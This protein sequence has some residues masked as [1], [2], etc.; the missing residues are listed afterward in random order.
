MYPLLGNHEVMR[1]VG[2]WRYVSEGEYQSF[3]TGSSSDVRDAVY[4]RSAAAE[5]SRAKEQKRAFD[6]A[7]FRAQFMREVPLGY[8]EMR[9]AFAEQGEYGRWLRGGDTV[10]RINGIVFLHG[11]V[12][13]TAAALGCAG[14][15]EAVRRDIQGPPPPPEKVATMFA[16][17]ETG[18]VWYRGLAQQPESS[19]EPTLE[20]ILAALGG[21]AIVVGHTPVLPGRIITRFGGRV[22]QI[23][24]GMLDTT[25][26]PGG[27]ASALEIK[28]GVFTAIYADRREPLAT[29]A[30][31]SRAAA[32][33][34]P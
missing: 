18:P 9:T 3:R 14:I 11:G 17:S 10:I 23:D 12:S 32:T 7:A 2:D 26:F 31:E 13:E 29:P 5:A 25:F 15:N 16:T 6:D 33:A 1:I 24:S 22:I 20:R 8:I 4:E 19:F 30:L 27:V 21:R 34:T 28:D